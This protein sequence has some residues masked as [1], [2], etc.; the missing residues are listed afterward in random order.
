[1]SGS[2]CQYRG[3]HTDRRLLDTRIHSDGISI[4]ALAVTL[5]VHGF[6][7]RSNFCALGVDPTS[8]VLVG[9]AN[10]LFS[11]GNVWIGKS[12]RNVRDELF[13]AAGAWVR[14]VSFAHNGPKLGIRIS[15][16]IVVTNF[17]AFAFTGP[18]KLTAEV[19]TNT[20]GKGKGTRHAIVAGH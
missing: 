4:I 1:L 17:S 13:R 20:F 19:G 14:C 7:V 12:L 3:K 10:A 8:I 2:P 9:A 6:E 16:S 15:I 5:A 18:V 11:I